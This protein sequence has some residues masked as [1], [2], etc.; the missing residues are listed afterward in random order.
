[1]ESK[2]RLE[3]SGGTGTKTKQE[4]IGI[5]VE[6]AQKDIGVEKQRDVA[7]DPTAQSGPGNAEKSRGPGFVARIRTGTVLEKDFKNKAVRKRGKR[8]GRVRKDDMERMTRGTINNR[9]KQ[10]RVGLVDGNKKTAIGGMVGHQTA[11]TTTRT[12]KR[13]KIKRRR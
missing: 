1:M 9:D 10:R 11:G 3:K 13:G 7:M 8:A 4:R 6:V 12:G 2:K 5:E